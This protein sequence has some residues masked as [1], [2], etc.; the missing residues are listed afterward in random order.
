[1]LWYFRSTTIFRLLPIKILYDYIPFFVF[2]TRYFCFWS[3]KII[4]IRSV[5]VCFLF[6]STIL[7]N[8]QNK[9]IVAAEK[10]SVFVDDDEE[11]GLKALT[12]EMHRWPFNCFHSQT[13]FIYFN[14]VLLSEWIF[15]IIFIF[16]L[17]FIFKQ[18]R[19]I[20]SKPE[21]LLADRVQQDISH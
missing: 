3:L 15:I 9:L 17:G 7:T 5:S 14:D 13:Q 16:R 4:L 20:W 21:D 12:K 19:V 1:M 11:D 18:K 6:I 10:T 2:Y 8:W